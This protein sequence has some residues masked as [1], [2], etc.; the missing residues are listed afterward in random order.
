MDVFS[1]EDVLQKKVVYESGVDR[2]TKDWK[3]S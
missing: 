3:N 1:K 2:F